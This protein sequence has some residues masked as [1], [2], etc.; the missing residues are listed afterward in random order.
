M[1]YV[2]NNL[3]DQVAAEGLSP[4]VECPTCPTGGGQ[5]GEQPL[6]TLAV[7]ELDGATVAV[8]RCETCGV[9]VTRPAMPDVSPLYAGRESEDFQQRDSALATAIKDVAF[10]RL[11]RGVLK[12]LPTKPCLI[13]DYGC[14]NGVLT[15]AFARVSAGSSTVG[16]DFFETQ[17]GQIAPASYAPFSQ[18]SKFEGQADLLLCFHA[19]EHDDDPHAFL[20]RLKALIRPGGMLVIEVP[21][22]D[23][24][25]TPWFGVKCN[26][27]YLPYHRLHF[28]RR[29]LRAAIEA[30]GLD[31]MHEED[32]CTATISMS[33]S[34]WMNMRHNA[35]FFLA[36]CAF[37]PF[38]LLAEKM[39]RRPSGLR[40]F[41]RLP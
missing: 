17:P 30:N 39:S 5:F 1:T 12:R 28:S 36:G 8:Y 29:S 15:S 34:R 33:L 10:R 24:V 22:V 32:V 18:S 11:A 25:W 37:R 13:L 4:P 2:A 19:L 7:P 16:L 35:L 40:I 9:G 14:G 21:N 3:A 6:I 31:V 20:S 23:C 38:Q 26:N 27:W 41:A